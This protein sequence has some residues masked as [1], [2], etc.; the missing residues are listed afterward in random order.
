[1]SGPASWWLDLP[2][3]DELWCYT[4]NL[5]SDEECDFIIKVGTDPEIVTLGPGVV[6]G[7]GSNSRVDE[8]IRKST[9]G[10]LPVHEKT[11]WIFQRITAA[12]TNINN[13][14]YKYDLTHIENIQFTVYKEDSNFYGQHIDAMYETFKVHA[15]SF[16]SKSL[17]FVEAGVI[18]GGNY[19]YIITWLRKHLD[20]NKKIITLSLYENLHSRFKSDFVGEYYDNNIEDLTFW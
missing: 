14:F 1:M 4:H 15:K 2:H 13:D 5:F 18:R 12:V 11:N 10:W 19:E 6:G 7:G 3:K 9:I 16:Q 17:I 8:D 20:M